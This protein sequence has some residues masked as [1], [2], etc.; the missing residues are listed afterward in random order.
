MA[1]IRIITMQFFFFWNT[2]N[3]SLHLRLTNISILTIQCEMV[4][5]IKMKV[6]AISLVYLGLFC[7]NTMKIVC[8]RERYRLVFRYLCIYSLQYN[9]A[10]IEQVGIRILCVHA[11]IFFPI[12]GRIITQFD[13]IIT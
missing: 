5:Y 12:V 4:T 13:A 11:H 3:Y 8:E 1:S 10:A 7:G 2:T 6:C 9:V